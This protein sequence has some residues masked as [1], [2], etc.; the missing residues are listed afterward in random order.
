VS[1]YTRYPKPG[2]SRRAVWILIFTLLLLLAAN[3]VHQAGVT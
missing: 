2:P 3:L 1:D